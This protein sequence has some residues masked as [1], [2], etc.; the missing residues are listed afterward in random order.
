MASKRS[1]SFSSLRTCLL[2]HLEPASV[3]PPPPVPVAVAAAVA[4]KV[5]EEAALMHNQAAAAAVVAAAQAA[6]TELSRT[7]GEELL[8]V[9]RLAS[10]VAMSA[11]SMMKVGIAYEHSMP[12]TSH[13]TSPLPLEREADFVLLSQVAVLQV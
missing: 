5:D 10:P 6:S 3:L 13:Q 1:R 4:P 9:L 8:L 11:T 2:V 7:G 12:P